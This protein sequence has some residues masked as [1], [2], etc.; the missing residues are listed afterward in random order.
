MMMYR[1]NSAQTP[2]VSAPMPQPLLAAIAAMLPENI[3]TTAWNEA[4]RENRR[5]TRFAKRHSNSVSYGR[6][7]LNGPRAVARRLAAI[8]RTGRLACGALAA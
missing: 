8:E 6:A 4:W 1:R 3:F 2:R 5:R 7:G